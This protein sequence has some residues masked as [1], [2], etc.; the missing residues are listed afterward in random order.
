VPASSPQPQPDQPPGPFEGV[1]GR[2]V[3]AWAIDASILL[4]LYWLIWGG[5][6]LLT[7]LTLGLTSG[8][9]VLL[10]WGMALPILYGTLTIASPLSATPG[11]AMMGLLVRSDAGGG[12]PSLGQA[13]TATTLYALSWAAGGWPLLAPLASA[14]SRTLH[15]L[16]SGTLVMRAAA[17]PAVRNR[18]PVAAARHGRGDLLTEDG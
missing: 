8:L 9:L 15:D 10:P 13:F 11:Q 4:A 2:R 14:R 17:M 6:A 1:I 3:A 12:A 7:L 5:A 18:A 16:F